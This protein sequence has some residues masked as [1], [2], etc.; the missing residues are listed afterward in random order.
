[1]QSAGVPKV[2]HQPNQGDYEKFLTRAG[3]VL[4]LDKALATP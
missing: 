1:M 4:G 2:K 3:L